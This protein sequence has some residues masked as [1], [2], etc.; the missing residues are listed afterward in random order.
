L[1]IPGKVPGE[2]M[3]ARS[4]RLSVLDRELQ[5]KFYSRFIGKVL[6]CTPEGSKNTLLSDNY[7]R[8]NLG[9]KTL[10]KYNKILKM[11]I[12][13]RSGTLYAVPPLAV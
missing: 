9:S 4:H 2:V 1:S 3:R 8:L 13:E 12:V 5:K 7:I 11:T 10:S 6:E